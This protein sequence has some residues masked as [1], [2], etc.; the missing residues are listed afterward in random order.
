MIKIF[1][2]HFCMRL[3]LIS[4][5][6]N[7]VIGSNHGLPCYVKNMARGTQIDKNRG[8]RPSFFYRN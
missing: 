7:L 5:V 1:D 2:L 3:A 6:E 4:H 8:R